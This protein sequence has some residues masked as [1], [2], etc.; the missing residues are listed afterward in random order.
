[1]R[2][3]HIFGI[4]QANIYISNLEN[5]IIFKYENF[6][7]N[8]V[9]VIKELCGVFEL[10]TAHNILPFINKQYQP[11]G[12]QIIDQNEFYGKENLS[13]IEQICSEQ[14]AFF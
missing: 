10:K 12:D 6:I 14:I 1:M 7:A 4:F 9:K 11:K 13:L 2:S 5:I 8:K 3:W